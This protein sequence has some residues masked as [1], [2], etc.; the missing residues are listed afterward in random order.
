MTSVVGSGVASI[1]RPSSS[2][3]DPLPGASDMGGIYQGF[4]RRALGFGLR[5]SG[6]RLQVHGNV[7]RV[8]RPGNTRSPKPGALLVLAEIL[9]RLGRPEHPKLTERLLPQRGILFRLS[10]FD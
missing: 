10:D 3:F 4:G 1:R 6:F 2:G 9:E 7:G 5:A 8:F